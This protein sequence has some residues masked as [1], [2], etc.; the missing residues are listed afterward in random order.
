ME[1]TDEFQDWYV[2]LD[3]RD[4]A[5]VNAAVDIL[6]DRGPMLGRPL[7]DTLTGSSVPNLKELR[8]TTSIRVLFAFDPRRTAILLLGGNN[9]GRW[10][11]WYRTAIPGAEALYREHLEELRRGGLL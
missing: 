11:E 6:A 1:V 10:R 4:T 3:D 5:A 8:P 2:A 9:R 7:V